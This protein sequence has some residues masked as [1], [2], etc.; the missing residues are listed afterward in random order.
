VV[1]VVFRGGKTL[2]GVISGV[3]SRDGITKGVVGLVR[4][5]KHY[6]QVR[7]IILD[8]ETLPSSSCLDI[9]LI[10]QELGLPVIY[11]HRGDGFDPRFM[12]RWRN[13]VVEPYGLT[14]GTVERILNLVFDKGVGML[15]VAHLIAR[16]LDLMHNV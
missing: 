4:E 7:V 10:Y 14:E 8:D 2:D 16:N 9:Q 1:C 12:T 13:R 5:S 6:G 15:R 3:F 11:L